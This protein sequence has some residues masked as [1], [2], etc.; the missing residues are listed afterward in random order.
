[1]SHSRVIRISSNMEKSKASQRARSSHISW[2]LMLLFCA[3]LSAISSAQTVTLSP[4]AKQIFFGSTGMYLDQPLSAGKI[5]TYSAGTTSPLA[6]YVDSTGNTANPNPILLDAA[7]FANIWLK[8]GFAYKFVV[9]D[10]NGVQQYVVDNING[11]SGSSGTFG[12]LNGTAY[13]SAF[14]GADCGLKIAAALATG[15]GEVWVDTNAGTTNCSGFTI[16]AGQ[17]VKFIQAGTWTF[18]G[19][20]ILSQTSSLTGP[21]KGT[22][23]APAKLKEA[24]GTNL[25]YLVQMNGGAS[26]LRDIYLDGNYTN[27]STAQDVVQVNNAN[28]VGLYGVEIH[29]GKRYGVYVTGAS[30]CCGRIDQSSIIADNNNSNLYLNGPGPSDWIINTTEFENSVTG[31]GIQAVNAATA[32]ITNSDVG[33][34]AAGGISITASGGNV[35]YGWMLNTIQFGSNSGPDFTCDGSALAYSNGSHVMTGLFFLGLKSGTPANTYDAIHLHDCGGSVIVGNYFGGAGS[36]AYRYHYFSDTSNGTPQYSNVTSNVAN[37]GG[38]ATADYHGLASDA[39]AGVR[40]GAGLSTLQGFTIPNNA[41]L[42]AQDQ[43]GNNWTAIYPYSGHL[44]IEGGGFT[45][46]D[47]YVNIVPD[48]TTSVVEFDPTQTKFINNYPIQFADHTGVYRSFAQVDSSDH[49]YIIG[50]AGL[51]LNF[52][53]TGGV[54]EAT[55]TAAS[56]LNVI[57]GLKVNGV[58]VTT[59]A[60]PT[61]GQAA[62]IYAAGPPLQIGKC[63]SVVGATGAC[64]CAP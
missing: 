55:M 15:A 22:N 63:T 5:Y 47:K 39:I 28:R 41:A 56:G 61:V 52:Q 60:T 40:A 20:I 29:N 44:T 16:P 23:N 54:T 11:V 12:L 26:A 27:N 37:A 35:A 19:S 58:S 30:S 4:V 53:P 46:D 36:S 25:A 49:T 21:P 13:A 33:G 7:G 32:R 64:T 18:T 62:C 57:H 3:C 34:N 48:A 38:A 17:R 59:A 1:M 10:A 14:T 51:D 6:T 42:Y 45:G 31:Y 43:N 8:N 2:R 24:N 9:Q 50:N